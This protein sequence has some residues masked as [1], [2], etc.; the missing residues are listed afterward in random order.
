MSRALSSR[1]GHVAV[2]CSWVR[3]FTFTGPLSTQDY[4]WILLSRKP[5]AGIAFEMY[6]ETVYRLRSVLIASRC[7]CYLGIPCRQEFS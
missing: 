7:N 2:L 1:L 6:L 3:H 5:F 4:I